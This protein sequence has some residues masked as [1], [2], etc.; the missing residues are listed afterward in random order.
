MV[1]TL[2]WQLRAI[3]LLNR[4]VMFQ[5]LFTSASLAIQSWT[6][7]F[8]GCVPGIYIV[9]HTFGSNIKFNPHF[10]PVR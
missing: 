6:K 2:P 4:Q 1:F 3:C 5:L 8:G 7:E 9:L 10:Y